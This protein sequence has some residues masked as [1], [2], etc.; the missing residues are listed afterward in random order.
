[1]PVVVAAK[2]AQQPLP[3]ASLAIHLVVVAAARVEEAVR[4]AREVVVVVAEAVAAVVERVKEALIFAGE[5][6]SIRA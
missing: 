3:I 1:M 6:C 2:V 4:L 5:E